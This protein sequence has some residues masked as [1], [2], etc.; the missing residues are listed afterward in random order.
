MH[1][2]VQL[3]NVGLTVLA[4]RGSEEANNTLALEWV[5][6]LLITSKVNVHSYGIKVLE[7]VAGKNPTAIPNT[8]A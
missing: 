7:M 1:R 3:K 2:V 6:N 8:D 4:S 5:F